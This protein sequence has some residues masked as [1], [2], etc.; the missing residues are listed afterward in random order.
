MVPEGEGEPADVHERVG[1]P[2][3]G[4]AGIVE[5]PGGFHLGVEGGV[6]GLA[7]LDVEE[8]RPAYPVHRERRVEFALLV[9]LVVV[10]G[11]AV[12]V[13]GVGDLRDRLVEVGGVALRASKVSASW[14]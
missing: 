6:D 2:L 5:D 7:G 1:A 10:G 3:G 13:D 11:A 4:G 9:D 12:T 14:C 8:P